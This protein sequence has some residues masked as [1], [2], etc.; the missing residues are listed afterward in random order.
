MRNRRGNGEGSIYQRADG[1]WCA[2]ITVGYDER[3]K[4][5]RR[6][7]FGRTKKEVRDELTKLSNQK[8]NGTLRGPSRLTVVQFLK[9]WIEDTKRPPNCRWTTYRDY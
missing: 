2:T 7:V 6:T 5:R 4:R 1:R 8:L 9:R 3:G